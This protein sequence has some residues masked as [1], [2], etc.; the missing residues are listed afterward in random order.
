MSR[1]V[2]YLLY[3][4]FSFLSEENNLKEIHLQFSNSGY[5]TALMPVDRIIWPLVKLFSVNVYHTGVPEATIAYLNGQAQFRDQEP[6]DSLGRAFTAMRE[7]RKVEELVQAVGDSNSYR[8]PF[9]HRS[10]SRYRDRLDWERPYSYRDI[11]AFRINVVHDILNTAGYV[12]DT[13]DHYMILAVT[14]LEREV[15]DSRENVE[16]RANRKIQQLQEMLRKDS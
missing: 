3:S 1:D 15:H 16:R 9:S 12:N 8:D 6:Y 7:S 11:L 10:L 2:N 4:L 14:A 13:L 5:N